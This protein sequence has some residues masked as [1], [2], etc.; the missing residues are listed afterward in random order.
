[1]RLPFLIEK[2][3]QGAEQIPALLAQPLGQPR[4]KIVPERPGDPAQKEP[5]GGQG[6]HLVLD[7]RGIIPPSFEKLNELR[8]LQKPVARPKDVVDLVVGRVQTLEQGPGRV[9]RLVFREPAGPFLKAPE[10]VDPAQAPALARLENS[11]REFRKPVL[12]APVVPFPK[13]P[14][15]SERREGPGEAGMAPQELRA[16]LLGFK[17]EKAQALLGNQI[18]EDG[19]KDGPGLRLVLMR[20]EENEDRRQPPVGKV[21]DQDPEIVAQGADHVFPAGIAGVVAPGSQERL[22]GGFGGP[23]SL[24]HEDGVNPCQELGK[25]IPAVL[26]RKQ[27]GEVLVNPVELVKNRL[28]HKEFL[29]QMG[30]FEPEDLSWQAFL[31]LGQLPSQGCLQ[32][33]DPAGHFEQEIHGQGG[34]GCLLKRPEDFGEGFAVFEGKVGV[35]DRSDPGSGPDPVLP[36]CLK[37]QRLEPAENQPLVGLVIL[38]Q[39]QAETEQIFLLFLEGLGSQGQKVR[40]LLENLFPQGVEA[41]QKEPAL[42]PRQFAAAV[43]AEVFQKIAEVRRFGCSELGELP[44]VGN[45]HHD[46]EHV[47][48]SVKKNPSLTDFPAGG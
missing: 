35:Q 26:K 14:F 19:V 36:G 21:P 48:I 16:F 5:H 34:E 27:Q 24:G 23:R 17:Q 15:P 10:V 2:P 46:E 1:M 40:D 28:E 44:V 20:D 29:V 47:S 33:F 8:L 7:H 12:P 41:E 18:A 6:T 37:D 30:A 45:F 25:E 31:D 3:S 39:K 13:D 32:G 43:E 9:G 11:G 42:F 22:P 4:A 38:F